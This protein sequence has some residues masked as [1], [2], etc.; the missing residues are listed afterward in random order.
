MATEDHA[1]GL[2]GPYD[3]HVR[4]GWPARRTGPQRV[5]PSMQTNQNGP[6][7][8]AGCIGQLKM[9]LA[10]LRII[11]VGPQA[12]HWL[13]GNVDRDFYADVK[14]EPKDVK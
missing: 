5:L 12:P 10:H 7:V 8:P 13:L 9:A 4:G 1:S 6:F 2:L 14:P 11:G 3:C